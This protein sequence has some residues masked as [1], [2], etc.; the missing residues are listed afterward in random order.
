MPYYAMVL[1]YGA[2]WTFAEAA[3]RGFEFALRP[4][5][6]MMILATLLWLKEERWSK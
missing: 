1:A 6:H 5:V 3:T 4:L 2:G